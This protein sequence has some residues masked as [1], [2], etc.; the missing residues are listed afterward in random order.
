MKIHTVVE[1]AEIKAVVWYDPTHLWAMGIEDAATGNLLQLED[2]S[3]AEYLGGVGKKAAFKYA[4][5]LFA[6]AVA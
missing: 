6:K 1:N 3:S 5:E 4:S 2:G